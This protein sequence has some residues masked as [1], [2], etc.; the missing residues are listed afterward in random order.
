MQ[1]IIMTAILMLWPVLALAHEHHGHHEIHG[2]PGPIAGAGLPI[3]V[4]LGGMWL[5]RRWRRR[6]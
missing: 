3:L 2:A 1:R 6:A 4:G 5:W